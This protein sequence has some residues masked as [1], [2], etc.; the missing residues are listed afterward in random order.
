MAQRFINPPATAE[1]FPGGKGCNWTNHWASTYC[2]VERVPDMVKPYLPQSQVASGPLNGDPTSG[3]QNRYWPQP[4]MPRFKT[5]PLLALAPLL[6]FLSGRDAEPG[7]GYFAERA[8][9]ITKHSA[10]DSTFAAL[11]REMVTEE[12]FTRDYWRW[13]ID[14]YLYG[15]Y[16]EFQP[17][18]DAFARGKRFEE[19]YDLPPES[20]SPEDDAAAPLP[21]L[22]AGYFSGNLP[23]NVHTGSTI[24]AG[25]KIYIAYQGHL[26]DPYIAG[27]DVKTG[28]WEGPFK[29]GHSTLSKDGRKIDSHGRPALIQDEHGYFHIV[30]GGHGGE[31]EDGLNPLSIDTPHA[32]GRLTHVM[33]TKPNDISG[34]QVIADVSPFAS[35]GSIFKMGDGDIYFFTRAGTHKSPWVFY[36]MAS[37]SQRFDPPVLITWPTPQPESPLYVDTFYINP[38]KVSDTEILISYLWHECNF[39]ELHNKRHYHRIN[40]YYMRMDTTDDSFH[41][42]QNQRLTLPLD[43]AASDQLTLAYDSTINEESCFSTRPLVLADGRPAAAYEAMG[44]DYRYWRMTVYEDGAWTSGLP[45]P[46]STNQNLREADGTKIKREFKLHRFSDGEGDPS[47]AVVYRDGR[48]ETVFASATLDPGSA[49]GGE[50]WSVQTEFIRLAQAN[51]QMRPINDQSGS[52]V[53]LVLNVKKGGAQRLYLWHD[54]ALRAAP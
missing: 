33:S 28:E 43:K 51:I 11:Q 53:A 52:T 34:F 54:G 2:P 40:T 16:P 45:L 13:R 1:I 42:A 32:G 8:A 26:T 18:Y 4:V 46:E 6:T 47:A 29:A 36:R 27:Y 30:F 37:G 23:G 7:T 35:Y 44:P 9:L 5:I 12:T 38:L 22:P 14:Q 24:V 48:G 50:S 3:G 25:D 20:L 21:D 15:Q 41:N 49:Q 17:L 31:R 39:Y 19:L 10:Q